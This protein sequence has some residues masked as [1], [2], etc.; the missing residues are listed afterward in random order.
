MRAARSTPQR[1]RYFKKA[2]GERL[3]STISSK[4]ERSPF[5]SA[6]AW[7]LKS[8]IGSMWM[9]ESV[10]KNSLWR[11]SL[12][13][14]SGGVEVEFKLPEPG[15]EAYFSLIFSIIF[16]TTVFLDPPYAPSHRYRRAWIGL[17]H[18][19]AGE[20]NWSLSTNA[21]HGDTELR[22]GRRD[23]VPDERGWARLPWECALRLRCEKRR[24]PRAH[25]HR[26]A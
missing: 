14:Y 4:F 6:S 2:A 13:P 5:I 1:S 22:C 19:L 9:W 23:Q 3:N 12:S 15:L 21:P 7:G 17:F 26:A 25:E 11:L 10:I 16:S 8:S 24:I 18:N 20:A